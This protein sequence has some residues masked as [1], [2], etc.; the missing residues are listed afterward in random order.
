[1]MLHCVPSVLMVV[2]AVQGEYQQEKQQS[3]QQVADRRKNLAVCK[4]CL[5]Y[6]VMTPYSI[7]MVAS[8][9]FLDELTCRLSVVLPLNPAG[10]KVR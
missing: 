6:F 1:M 5:S 10:K 8:Y 7:S 3:V 9:S 2:L 4:R